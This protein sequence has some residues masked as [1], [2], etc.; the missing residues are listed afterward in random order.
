MSHHHN[1]DH[2][3]DHGDHHHHDHS[4][5][6]LEMTFAEKIEKLLDH[7][8]HHNE[9]HA[10]SY[11]GWADQAKL[12]HMDAVAAIIEEAAQM[13]RTMNEN[14]KK[15]KPCFMI[16]NRQPGLTPCAGSS[17]FS[18]RAVVERKYPR[19]QRILLR[20]KRAASWGIL[21]FPRP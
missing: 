1:H 16:I 2:D 10:A 17:F 8:I 7:W 20:N 15:P 5:G 11:E 3:H 13:N 6:T 18:F 9:D 14:L 12:N 19:W 21:F 4:H